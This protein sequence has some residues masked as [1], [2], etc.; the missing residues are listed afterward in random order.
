MIKK[1]ST[2]STE[3]VRPGQMGGMVDEYNK[4]YADPLAYANGTYQSNV[5]SQ[6]RPYGGDRDARTKAVKPWNKMDIPT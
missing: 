4:M 6:G 2:K 3:A 5:K 1:E